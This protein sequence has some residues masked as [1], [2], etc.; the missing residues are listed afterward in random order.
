MLEVY[1]VERTRVGGRNVLR[2]T[3]LGEF[4]GGEAAATECGRLGKGH[5]YVCGPCGNLYEL[6]V[7]MDGTV[8]S[9]DRH[10]DN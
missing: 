2:V 3:Y 6:F 10:G 7:S 8:R 5:Y 4:G 1:R 9:S